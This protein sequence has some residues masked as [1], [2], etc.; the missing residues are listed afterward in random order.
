MQRTLLA[1][2]IIVSLSACDSNDLP[3]LNDS[4]TT[5]VESNPTVV[6]AS[7]GQTTTDTATDTET[8]V[9]TNTV[10]IND[11]AGSSTSDG[12]ESISDDAGSSSS[13]GGEIADDAA[14]GSSDGGESTTVLEQTNT[15]GP[16]NT[17]AGTFESD[18]IGGEV[19]RRSSLSTVA[20]ET[21]CTTLDLQNN[22]SNLFVGDLSLIHI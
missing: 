4:N 6:S 7:G 5:N 19:I 10:V 2:V 1:S 22:F 14:S 21:I 15:P 16:V 11:D 9:A 3:S 13:D 17:D 18:N 20:S 12:G 8:V